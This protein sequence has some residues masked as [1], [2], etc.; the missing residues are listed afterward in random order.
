MTSYAWFV[1]GEKHAALAQT[2]MAAVRRADPQARL[3]VATDEAGLVIPGA[4]M[5]RFAP[6]L[7]LMVANVEAQLTVMWSHRT[8]VWFIDTD[9]LIL[10]PMPEQWEEG[11]TVTWRDTVGGEIED[12]PGGV[13]EVMPYNYGVIGVLPGP[14][15]I[16]A[17]LWVRERIR[18]MSPQL[19]LW[20]GNQIALAAFCGQRPET[21]E[22]EE[23][24][25]IPWRI[26]EPGP[27]VRVRKIPGEIWNYTPRAIDEDLSA[28]G[29]IHFKGHTRPWMKPVAESLQLNWVEAA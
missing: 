7:P 16:E 21:P 24:R 11:I 8:P 14:R 13:A 28:K 29:A 23:F 25:P 3:I 12:M 27:Q 6:G 2:S 20:W 15:V 19:Q 22:S 17:F 5:V 1:R 10:K 4:E 18:R 9:V 26:E